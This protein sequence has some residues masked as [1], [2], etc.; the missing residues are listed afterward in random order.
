MRKYLALLIGIGICISLSIA[1]SLLIINI[2]TSSLTDDKI[3][4]LFTTMLTFISTTIGGLFVFSI[5]KYYERPVLKIQHIDFRQDREGHSL[6]DEQI[7]YLLNNKILF[8]FIKKRIRWSERIIEQNEFYIIHL[9]DLKRNIE[10]Y[11]KYHCNRYSWFLPTKDKFSKVKKYPTSTDFLKIL[12]RFDPRYCEENQV[13]IYRDIENQPDRVIKFLETEFTAY[14]TKI[15]HEKE[16]LDSISKKLTSLI[17]SAQHEQKLKYIDGVPNFRFFVGI[18]NIGKTSA[19]V[20]HSAE[21]K[22]SDGKKIIPLISEDTSASIMSKAD[23]NE[24][25]GIKY[26]INDLK[27]TKQN[28]MDFND[29]VKQNV[30]IK[31][32]LIVDALDMKIVKKGVLPKENVDIAYFSQELL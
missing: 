13:S 25:I 19:L 7:S 31:I 8:E 17:E 18:S 15:N 1:F 3:K 14:E 9:K 5:N 11:K 6:E 29:L 16:L 32:D 26:V 2:P 12:S 27:V 24:I 28:L 21:L 10:K 4:V 22:F 23:P 20:N 30:S